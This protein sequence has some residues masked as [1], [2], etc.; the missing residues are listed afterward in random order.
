[1]RMLTIRIRSALLTRFRT[2]CKKADM[3]MT[4]A[5]RVM[6]IIFVEASENDNLSEKAKEMGKNND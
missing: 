3:S 2:A 5:L 6:I 1:M 4:K